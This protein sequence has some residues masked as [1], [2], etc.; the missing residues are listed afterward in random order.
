MES[1][2]AREA[3]SRPVRQGDT[4]HDEEEAVREAAC[5]L[6][7]GNPSDATARL[8][9]A[10][11]LGD[12]TLFARVGE[13]LAELHP[14][15]ALLVARAL[16]SLQAHAAAVSAELRRENR[17]LAERALRDP[18]T[19]V[20]NR[21]ALED[22]LRTEL[23]RSLRYGLAFSVLFVD[24]DH[25][26]RVNDTFGHAAGDRVLRDVAEAGQRGLRPGDV[27]GRYG[28]EEFLVGLAFAPLRAALRTAERLRR[29]V[30]RLR[31]DGDAA[32]ARV[33]IS[34]GVATMLPGSPEPLAQLVDHADRAM[35]QAKASGRNA[36]FAF[37]TP[38][39]VMDTGVRLSGASARPE[40]AHDGAAVPLRR[41]AAR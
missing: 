15:D 2:P 19:R 36:V 13:H 11:A 20:A 5:A 3:S 22:A 7:G 1:T 31:F 41:R 6:F 21:A 4:G 34:V 37:G 29:D 17:V 12:S 35:F 28:G 10:L 24:V 25:F 38:G 30:E 16:A 9:A 33:T 40:R 18:L 32:G 39:S 23:R 8:R 27:F 14:G 26:K